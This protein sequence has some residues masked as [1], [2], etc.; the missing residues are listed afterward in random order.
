MKLPSILLVCLSAVTATAAGLPAE[1]LKLADDNPVDW[2]SWDDE[3][4]ARAQV[5]QRPIFLSVGDPLNELSGSMHR[6]TFNNAEVAA[7]LNDTFVCV[8]VE[9]DT[10]PGIA[11]YGQQ[12]LAATQQLP[13]WP[14]NLWFTPDLQPIE[15]ASYLPPTEEWGREGFMI[16]AERVGSGWASDPEASQRQASHNAELIADYL[17]YPP[18]PPDDLAEALEFAVEDWLAI[19]DVENGLFGDPPHPIEPELIRFLIHAGDEAQTGALEMLRTRLSG[20]LR[21]PVDG[22][23]Y[24]GTV[25]LLGTIPVFQ[26]R[27]TDQARMALACLDAAQVSDDPIFAA[28]VRSALDYALARLSPAGDG[29]FIVG[30]DATQPE[31]TKTHT[32]THDQLV[33][34]IGADAATALGAQADG[35][36]DPEEDLEGHHAGR[37]ILRASPAASQ[38]R[39]MF[40]LRAKLLT[41]RESHGSTQVHSQ[42]TLGAHAL[43]VHALNRAA[44]ELGDLD[45]GQ[46][47]VAC[48]AALRRDFSVGE[49][50]WTRIAQSDV[51]ATP[52]DLLLLAQALNDDGLLA[53]TDTQFL[54]ADAG[55]YFATEH[56]VFGVR[57]HWW[58]PATGDL[59]APSVIRVQLGGAP[60]VVTTAIMAPLENFDVPPPGPVVLALQSASSSGVSP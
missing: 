20:A 7:F 31:A 56:D 42:A 57:P 36:V 28:G 30:E 4:I 16:V 37:N 13:G 50:H 54:D 17:P 44:I 38:T 39:A 48:K 1:L 19:A 59:P 3:A 41:V 21:D 9:R 2:Q 10:V 33:E 47:V 29:T 55:L 18:T 24:R 8:L 32:W 12:W 14:L 51:S 53:T 23:F 46:W 52:L 25:D 22:G 60:E 27:L 5:E 6:Q 26:K 15:G 58:N 49:N 40:E 35:N 11:A 43:M 45:Y 34:L